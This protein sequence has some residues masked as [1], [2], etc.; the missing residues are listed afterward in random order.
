MMSALAKKP[1]SSRGG[2]QSGGKYRAPDTVRET[3]LQALLERQGYDAIESKQ[4]SLISEDR[5]HKGDVPLW[6]AGHLEALVPEAV[7]VV[8]A[9]EVS[10]AGKL[11]AHRIARE[12]AQNAVTV[13]SGLAAGV[14]TFALQGALKGGGRVVAVLG[15]PLDRATPTAN[16]PLQEEIYTNHLLISQFRVGAQ[17]HKANFPARN[18]TMAALSAGTLIV[19]AS[20]TSG[21]L[22]QAAECTRLK[23]WLFVMKSVMDDAGLEWPR[24]FQKSYDRFVVVES[25]EDVLKRL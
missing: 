14:D 3:T 9:R 22:H 17:V 12:L 2:L 24:K 1:Q 8:G 21:T 13:V 7:S 15:T 18:R 19:E 6:Y 20:D 5:P 25:V 4:L 23:R 16:G 10:E 11:R